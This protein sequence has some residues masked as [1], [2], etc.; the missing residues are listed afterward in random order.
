M[1]NNNVEI[2][3]LEVR[4]DQVKIGISAPKDVPIFVYSNVLDAYFTTTFFTVPS[5]AGVFALATALR[6]MVS[7]WRT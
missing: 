5:P 7:F 3:I 1:V 6:S 4:G 2:T